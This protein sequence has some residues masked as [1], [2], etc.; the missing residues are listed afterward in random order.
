MYIY[1]YRYVHIPHICTSCIINV[2]MNVH[3]YIY[4]SIYSCI[5]TC[6]IKLKARS[7]QQHADER[8]RGACFAPGVVFGWPHQPARS[9]PHPQNPG[10]PSQESLQRVNL[11]TRNPTWTRRLLSNKAVLKKHGIDTRVTLGS[12]VWVDL[13]LKLFLGG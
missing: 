7:G 12:G 13:K 6:Y 1:I 2:C 3:I 11:Y 5:L 8:L 9:G 10:T 4:L